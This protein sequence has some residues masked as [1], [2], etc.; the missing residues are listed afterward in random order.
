[1]SKPRTNQAIRSALRSALAYLKGFAGLE[2][3]G[4]A[5]PPLDGRQ[6]AYLT[7]WVIP[8]LEGIAEAAN[9]GPPVP[10]WMQRIPPIFG[11]E[12]RPWE[13]DDPG[14]P[15]PID[16]FPGVDDLE[17]I[18]REHPKYRNA[19]WGGDY[20][21]VDHQKWPCATIA[22]VGLVE[23]YRARE[24]GLRKALSD[25]GECPLCGNSTRGEAEHDDECELGPVEVCGKPMEDPIGELDEDDDPFTCRK[26]D[27]HEGDCDDL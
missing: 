15:L 27:G 14:A 25:I 16:F 10:D 22:L 19:R 9:G 20:C 23:R 2:R 1:M 6:V 26:R 5:G 24:D 18:R 21:R 4:Y 12:P 17:S 8:R 3:R 13:T 11:D 7:T